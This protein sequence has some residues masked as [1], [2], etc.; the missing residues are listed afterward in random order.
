MTL[1]L[2]CNYQKHENSLSVTVITNDSNNTFNIIT[3]NNNNNNNN[4]NNKMHTLYESDTT[5]HS[6]IP[7][8]LEGSSFNRKFSVAWNITQQSFIHLFNSGNLKI[9]RT[10]GYKHFFFLI[11]ERN[12]SYSKVVESVHSS[13]SC[14]GCFT[15]TVTVCTDSGQ[16]FHTHPHPP[17]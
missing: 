17:P 3:W 2:W 6:G 8:P 1:W 7:G 13:I 10:S 16:I 14:P 15:C 9:H 11:N 5:K 12:P 4:N